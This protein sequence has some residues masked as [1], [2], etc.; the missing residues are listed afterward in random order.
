[1]ARVTVEDCV[2][3]IPNRFQLVIMASRRS[4]ELSVGNEPTLDRDNDKNP[5]I[6]LREIAEETVSLDQL[7]HSII[8]SMQ[9]NVDDD[10]VVE[11]E[12]RPVDPTIE[13][14]SRLNESAE[15]EAGTDGAS[16]SG[17]EMAWARAGAFEDVAP[18]E[19][20]KD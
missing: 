5:V 1:M 6:A 10:D 2:L 16:P 8:E 4:R 3:K 7:E 11:D 15:S 14:F 12:D 19:M 20:D 13:E 17:P 18:D 9:R